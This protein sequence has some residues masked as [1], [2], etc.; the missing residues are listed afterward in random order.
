M[1]KSVRILSLDGGGIRGI[2]PAA[3][4]KALEEKL[5]ARKGEAARI[6]DYFD[7][8]AGSSTGGILTC[9]YLC[10]EERGSAR[11]RFTAADA[12]NLY[13]EWGDDIFDIP[14]HH[15]LRTLGGLTDEKYPAAGLEEALSRH[16]G[17]LQLKDLLKPCLVTAY[18]IRRR[19]AFFFTQHDAVKNDDDNFD[20]V[21]VARSTSAAPTYF[22]C[23]MATSKGNTRHPM[24]DGGVFANNPALCAYAEARK[25]DGA[26]TAADMLILSLGTGE[27]RS[28]YSFGEARDWGLAQWIRPLV[29]IIM[30]GVSET[31]NYQL[32]KIYEAVGCEDQ[33]LRLQKTDLPSDHAEMDD[34]SR[35]NLRTLREMGEALAAV[36]DDALEAFAD[37][38]VE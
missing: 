22:E 25:M 28:P 1:A 36:H 15:K 19:Q 34:A 5:Q 4:L 12:L 18:D 7:L 11:P 8:I 9:L 37:R 35:D 6:A 23:A 13:M 31:V 14:F 16:F 2:I 17:D 29:D 38:L 26:P 24:I 21:D 20:L 30:S 10:P 27:V 3:V 33:Y 32:Q